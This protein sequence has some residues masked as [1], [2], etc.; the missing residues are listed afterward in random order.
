VVENKSKVDGGV[1]LRKVEYEEVMRDE[2][3][4]F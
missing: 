4:L 1:S 3:K 2:D